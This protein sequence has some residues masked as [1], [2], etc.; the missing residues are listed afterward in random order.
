MRRIPFARLTS[1]SPFVVWVRLSAVSGTRAAIG[2]AAGGSHMRGRRENG[3]ETVRGKLRVVGLVI[4][5]AVA[6]AAGATTAT[7]GQLDAVAAARLSIGSVTTTDFRAVLVA[8]KGD[9]GGGSPT[10]TVTLGTWRRV[11]GQWRRTGLHRVSGPY[12]WNTISGPR[13]VCRLEIRTARGRP[14]FRPV[15]AVQLLITPSVG[16]G[17]VHRYI[18]AER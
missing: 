11:A 12:F 5:A 1:N 4:A 8:A 7:G 17:R 13:S 14:V 6:T 3:S 15:V 18:L 9:G 2:A 10:A 16:C